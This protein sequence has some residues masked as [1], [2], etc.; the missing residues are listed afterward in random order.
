[1][2]SE[3]ARWPT[4]IS[5]C[6]HRAGHLSASRHLPAKSAS[7]GAGR[8]GA[9]T[10]ALLQ[11]ID[12]PYVPIEA[13][14]KRVRNTLSAS[15]KQKQTS[16]E[17]TSLSGEFYF[18][19]STAARI[20][21]YSATAIKDRT[22]VLYEA[23]RSHR[24]IRALKTYNWHSQNPALEKLTGKQI[25]GASQDNLFVL[26]RN[27]LQAAHGSANSAIDWINRFLEY[28]KDMK[29]TARKALLD[30]ILFEIFFDADGKLR[31]TPKANVFEE[32]FALQE[33]QALKSSFAFIASALVPEAH[34]FFGIPGK[35]HAVSVDVSVDKKGT[36][37]GIF[38]GGK[39]ILA[40]EDDFL[41]E[42]NAFRSLSRK[43]FEADLAKQMLVPHRLL[44]VTYNKPAKLMANLKMRHGYAAV[45]PK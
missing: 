40:I 32:V 24:V 45:R 42:S 44:T 30:G 41:A 22:F 38:F 17:H 2:G 18:N 36:V 21:E 39:N 11:H 31:E 33:Y 13:M 15:T 8:N 9:Y 3:V 10:A 25:A 19:L 29:P 14:F 27:I 34:H 4:R 7:D 43:Q 5:P 16:W 1:M 20:D 23:K 26:G 12:T 35:D 6:M 28:T 37:D